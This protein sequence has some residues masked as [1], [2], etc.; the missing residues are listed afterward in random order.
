[1]KRSSAV[2]SGIIAVFLVFIAYQTH[3][4]DPDT[5]YVRHAEGVVELQEAG[6]SQWM[7]AVVNTPLIEGDTVRTGTPGRT[8]LFMKDGSMIRVGNN[9]SLK[10]I[11]VEQNAV[12]LR[13][14]R[15]TTYVRAK[16]TNGLPVFIDTPMAAL[17]IA[18]P[19]VFRVDAYDDLTSEIAVYQGTIYA[20]Q[21][22]GK[23]PVKAGERI[24]LRTDGALPV[25]AG[26]RGAD[27]WL[28]WNTERDRVVVRDYSATESHAY[29]PE[30]LR[31]YSSDLDNHGRWIY[32]N[33]YSYVWV[34]TVITVSTWSPYRFGRWV[35]IRGSYVWVGYE[36]WGW[37]PY[38]YG[39]WVHHRHAGWCWVPPARGHVR[40]A[41]AH[42]AWVHS[43]RHVGWVPLSPG[44]NF[45]HRKAPVINQTNIYNIYNN[46]TIERSLTNTKNTYKN[47]RV[48]N[49]VVT[50]ERNQLLRHKAVNV[51]VERAGS[52]PLKTV[53]LPKNV[54]PARAQNLRR[55]TNG[56]R[57]NADG[58]KSDLRST[59]DGRTGNVAVRNMGTE[60]T[61]KPATAPDRI[62]SVT[63]YREGGT[64]R[65]ENRSAASLKDRIDNSRRAGVRTGPPAVQQRNITGTSQGPA[66]VSTIKN[67]REQVATR[68]FQERVTTSRQTD[69]NT[70]QRTS[71]QPAARTPIPAASPREEVTTTGRMQGPSVLRTPQQ[72]ARASA[73]SP[74][75]TV[76]APTVSG[77]KPAPTRE[78][79]SA[80][81]SGSVQTLNRTEQSP[82]ASRE[83]RQSPRSEPR[84]SALRSNAPSQGQ[85]AARVGP[86]ATV[87]VEK[88]PQSVAVQPGGSRGNDGRNDRG[89]P[90]TDRDNGGNQNRQGRSRR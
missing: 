40:W 59:F 67:N 37:A 80:V 49:S 31:V 2:I 46:V 63:N 23:M 70:T 83:S 17:D 68:P 81:P 53:S 33:D 14:D 4:A 35:W 36:P 41:P 72:P 58:K 18:S 69:D 79:P 55:G 56:G 20:V 5:F 39:R 62:I 52:V 89:T 12:Q 76:P 19:A 24:V 47:A 3:A 21:Q 27:E 77:Q 87:P 7:A 61:Q 32:T 51:N 82:L 11:A 84:S 65:E 22:K 86:S 29:L 43:S 74:T 73:A 30:E 88:Q 34:P 1:M 6:S 26:L 64:T 42:V 25:L 10:I 15:G 57:E 9:S 48:G 44:E 85:P 54:T 71:Q 75:G 60:G 78:R 28:R 90:E 8:E 66:G 38:H 13:L 50:M 45:D 16:G